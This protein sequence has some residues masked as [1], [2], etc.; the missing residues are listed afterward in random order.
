MPQEEAAKLVTNSVEGKKGLTY[1]NWVKIHDF[2]T[3]SGIT[4]DDLEPSLFEYDE[5]K[6][7]TI[8][9]TIGNLRGRCH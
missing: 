5:V 3:N 6:R 8:K 2:F 7:D 4:P 1:A 9:Q